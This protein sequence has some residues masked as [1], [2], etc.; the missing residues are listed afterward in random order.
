[1]NHIIIFA[2]LSLIN[3][4][5]TYAGLVMDQE[6][7]ES[8][9]SIRQNGKIYLQDNMFKV[10][11]SGQDIATVLDLDKN[12]LTY[13]NYSEKTYTLTT[14]E[15]L[16]QFFK[17][18]SEQIDSQIKE[19]LSKL[20]PDQK[21][22]VEKELK[23][24]GFLKDS[25]ESVKVSIKETGKKEKISG[26][27]CT[28]FEI[29]KNDKLN[30]EI[31]LSNEL[32]YKND[33]DIKKLSSF[34]NEF[35]KIGKSLGNDIVVDSD[36]AFIDL[37]EKNGYPLKTTDHSVDETVFVEEIKTITKKDISR[38]EFFPPKGYEF[39]SL[40]KLLAPAFN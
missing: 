7:Y 11:D 9:S 38:E 23:K 6:R 31:C 14:P 35:K 28:I 34:M 29:Y 12:Q 39:K 30:E 21:A 32:D 3:I 18:I 22:K 8:E 4:Q 16:L 27:T 2:A 20:P 26:Y 1:M 13:I 36:Q 5:F 40:E 33:V 19:D 15:E 25:T 17:R 37:F 10:Y 24:K